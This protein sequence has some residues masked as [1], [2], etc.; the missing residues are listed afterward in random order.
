MVDPP[1]ITKHQI[2]PYTVEEAWAFLAAA[3]RHR[4]NARWVVG[5]SLGL[6]QGEVLGLHG[7]TS[8][9]RKG[10]Y[11]YVVPSGCNPAALSPS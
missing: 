5:L 1:P 6:R 3:E 11:M 7:T 2:T 9:S 8:T 10:S 4:L